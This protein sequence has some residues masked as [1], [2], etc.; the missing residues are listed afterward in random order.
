VF[1]VGRFWDPGPEPPDPV[2]PNSYTDRA[3]AGLSTDAVVV[4]EFGHAERAAQTVRDNCSWVTF[5][6]KA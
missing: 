2:D 5:D 4:T 3:I 1:R 6:S